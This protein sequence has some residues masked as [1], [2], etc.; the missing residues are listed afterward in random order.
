MN[1][2]FVNYAGTKKNKLI[3]PF[4]DLTNASSI[5][6][7]EAPIK[8]RF[9]YQ[10]TTDIRINNSSYTVKN[11][12]EVKR[13]IDQGEFKAEYSLLKDTEGVKIQQKVINKASFLHAKS[14]WNQFLELSN[15]INYHE[16]Q[17]SQQ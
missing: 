11:A 16:L 15:H 5:H 10:I 4:L 14:T 12:L 13:I 6:Y 3:F 1:G 7:N 2:L 9:P 8:V 17:Y